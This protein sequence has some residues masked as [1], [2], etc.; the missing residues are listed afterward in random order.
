MSM[1][2]RTN[3]MAL[4]ANNALNKNNSTVAGNLEKLSSGFKIN[5]AADDAS[6]LAISE[7][8]K[9]QIKA[10]DQASKNA[11][12]GASLIKTAEGYMG[13]V[14]DMLN[15]IVELA[16]KSANGTFETVKGGVDSEDFGAAGT[17]R[18]ALQDE[19]DQLTAEIDRIATTANFNELKIMDGNLR[20]KAS[21][22]DV[23][24]KIDAVAAMKT[25][26]ATNEV[27][28]GKVS[29]AKLYLVEKGAG[30]NGTD[31]CT[32]ISKDPNDATLEKINN[33]DNYL[34]IGTKTVVKKVDGDN[35]T[36]ED[37]AVSY[38]KV[39]IDGSVGGLKLQIGETSTT[40]D[41]LQVNVMNFKTNKLFEAVDSFT[42]G[43]NKTYAD[44]K[45][46]GEDG[47]GLTAANAKSENANGLT[48]NI[49]NQDAASFAAEAVR[50]VINTVSSQRAELGALE[51]RI[52]YTINNLTTASE[53]ITD[54]NSRIRDTDMA[55]TMM[56]YT[57][58][59]VLTQ[60][61]QAMLAQANQAPSQ[62]LQLLQ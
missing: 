32:E 5:R 24:A 46:T 20:T 22:D 54:A 10:L 49:S 18:Q 21:A 39:N 35:T 27:N 12:D 42:N 48:I 43:D 2:V 28:V 6:G 7:K 29:E 45:A 37:S 15:R 38:T 9:A 33:E 50:S 4:N 30:A 58:G 16:E 26:T 36:Y 25:A 23:N 1:V 57:Q 8:M 3:A 13:E 40:S 19:V 60:A 55:K 17:D 47:N 62:V 44:V 31:K 34:A 56:Q 14:H 53:N 52:D 51:N 11:E 61:A 41:K 59:N